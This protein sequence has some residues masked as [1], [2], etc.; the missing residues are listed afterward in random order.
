MMKKNQFCLSV[1]LIFL[2]CLYNIFDFHL[3]ETPEP[4]NYVKYQFYRARLGNQLFQYASTY[5]IAKTNSAILCWSNSSL[6]QFN[7]H[8]YSYFSSFALNLS[9][10]P[11]NI[12]FNEMDE[13]G[14]GIY[15]TFPKEMSLSLR[16]YFQSYKYFYL[17][18]DDIRRTLTFS[19][20]ILQKRD[21]WWKQ[22][23]VRAQTY[24]GIHIRRNDKFD[25]P[26]RLR[27]PPKQYFINAMN[28][29]QDV[30]FIVVSN[31]PKWAR[32]QSFFHS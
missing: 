23:T 9:Q 11:N 3:D 29:F 15:T 28:Y 14:Y 7:R 24:V 18:E 16:G 17:Y 20:E 25:G 6:K 4:R 21:N 12:P 32:K 30:I 27:F 19:S 26:E 5:G 2:Y 1:I 13:K 10:C 31:D 8:K 22:N